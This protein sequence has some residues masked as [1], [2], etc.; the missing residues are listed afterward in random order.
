[1]IL[2]RYRKCEE[3]GV[4]Y[5]V[6]D[7]KVPYI[8]PFDKIRLSGTQMS[9]WQAY[10]LSETRNMFEMRDNACTLMHHAIESHDTI[11][12]ELCALLRCKGT[13]RLQLLQRVFQRMLTLYMGEASR[14]CVTFRPVAMRKR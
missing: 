14:P 8:W 3:N 6:E 2:S 10:L 7:N 5:Q 13:M 9:I 4:A 11:I 1:M 12:V